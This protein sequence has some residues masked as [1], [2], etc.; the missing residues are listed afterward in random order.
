MVFDKRTWL[1]RSLCDVRFDKLLLF[2][3]NK[4]FYQPT[5]NKGFNSLWQKGVNIK[6]RRQ[7]TTYGYVKTSL[8]R[9]VIWLTN[10]RKAVELYSSVS[11]V[12][13][14]VKITFYYTVD[15]LF[16]TTIMPKSLLK[17]SIAMSTMNSSIHNWK[18]LNTMVTGIVGIRQ[19]GSVYS[20]LNDLNYHLVDAW[21]SR[22]YKE[23]LLSSFIEN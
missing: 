15:L 11:F 12:K 2:H 20:K 16:S 3:K 17:M 19:Y 6:T 18:P 21:Q 8:I 14:R 4:G 22:K 7:F 23:L 10:G 1:E 13:R 9:S 5:H